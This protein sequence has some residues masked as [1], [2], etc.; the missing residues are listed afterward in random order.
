MS[1][2]GF[3]GGTPLAFEYALDV[4]DTAGL[5]SFAPASES[6]DLAQAGRIFRDIVGV[7]RLTPTAPFGPAGRGVSA[8]TAAM[9]PPLS[10]DTSITTPFCL[11]HNGDV[12]ST[13]VEMYRAQSAAEIDQQVLRLISNGLSRDESQGLVSGVLSNLA[14]SGAIS[15]PDF[16]AALHSLVPGAQSPLVQAVAS[17]EHLLRINFYS[18]DAAQRVLRQQLERMAGAGSLDPRN[19]ASAVNRVIQNDVGYVAGARPIPLQN[20]ITEGY[21]HSLPV[22]S[23]T[24]VSRAVP[25]NIPEGQTEAIDIVFFA[26]HRNLGRL[27]IANFRGLG[28]P[29]AIYINVPNRAEGNSG[30]QSSSAMQMFASPPGLEREGVTEAQR[31]YIRGFGRQYAERGADRVHISLRQ[32][33]LGRPT[34]PPSLEGMQIMEEGLRRIFD[35]FGVRGLIE[36]QSFPRYAP[37]LRAM[38]SAFWQ[39]VIANSTNADLQ[40]LDL[41]GINL[42]GADLSEVILADLDLTGG[43]LRNANLS[44]ADLTDTHLPNANMEGANL[45]EATLLGSNMRQA[46]LSDANLENANIESAIF[47]G[48]DLSRANFLDATF[49]GRISMR[50]ATLTDVGLSPTQLQALKLTAAQRSQLGG[51]EQDG[52]EN[53]GGENFGAGPV[54]KAPKPSDGGSD[55]GVNAS[56]SDPQVGERD[57]AGSPDVTTDKGLDATLDAVDKLVTLLVRDGDG[58]GG[59][60]GGGGPNAATLRTWAELNEAATAKQPERQKVGVTRRF[61]EYVVNSAEEILAPVSNGADHLSAQRHRIEALGQSL[62]GLLADVDDELGNPAPTA[63]TV[64]GIREELSAIVRGLETQYQQDAQSVRGQMS[65]LPSTPEADRLRT[66]TENMIDASGGRLKVLVDAI[67]AINAEQ[68]KDIQALKAPE[69]EQRRAGL[70]ASRDL[71]V[72]AKFVLKGLANIGGLALDG[73]WSLANFLY[74]MKP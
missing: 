16:S 28:E 60:G 29:G 26:G 21:V 4:A 42:R 5:N 25:G 47:N 1:G 32:Q 54:P 51:G 66:A 35:E 57:R 72:A 48:A 58:T 12:A 56:T 65:V 62:E 41:N 59:A 7:D 22:N 67:D 53:E 73:I 36:S 27:E 50:R 8:D 2:Y 71:A 74:R 39:Y 61:D 10:L 14:G 17:A 38:P 34:Q 11:A 9:I 69:A 37:L 15:T 64:D 40:A 46:K 49:S 43:N 70:E 18:D 23:E 45:Q 20:N 3:V 6:S 63:A 31:Q 19:L 55:Q 13:R 52:D 30:D 68:A 33:T 44:R 24:D